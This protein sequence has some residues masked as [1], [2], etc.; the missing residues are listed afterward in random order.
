M[1]N[2]SRIDSLFFHPLAEIGRG[3]ENEYLIQAYDAD[4]VLTIDTHRLSVQNLRVYEQEIVVE[5]A[6]NHPEHDT[7]NYHKRELT[8]LIITVLATHKFRASWQSDVI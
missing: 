7:Y 5:V 2:I 1:K 4:D 8:F 6:H 3:V